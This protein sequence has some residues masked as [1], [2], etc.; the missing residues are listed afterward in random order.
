[1]VGKQIKKGTQDSLG[2][3]AHLIGEIAEALYPHMTT[4]KILASFVPASGSHGCF[5]DMFICDGFQYRSNPTCM[6][7]LLNKLDR[8]T[9]RLAGGINLAR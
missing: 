5:R 7:E 3:Q 1:M 2:G 9:T 4:R 6:S 8:E